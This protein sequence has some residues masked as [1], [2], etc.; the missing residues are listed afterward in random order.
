MEL[1]KK[2]PKSMYALFNST[3]KFNYCTDQILVLKIIPIAIKA[4]KPHEDPEKMC[5]SSN[6]QFVRKWTETLM[7]D[8]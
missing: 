3:A 8:Q 1:A 5:V 2:I 4:T 6:V 7:D